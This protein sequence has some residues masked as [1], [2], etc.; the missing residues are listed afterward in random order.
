MATLLTAAP[1]I[2][3]QLEQLK[4]DCHDLKKRG[5]TPRMHVLLVGEHPPSVVYTRNK[6]RFC[7]SFGAECEI[8]RLPESISERDF[9]A[10][11]QEMTQDSKVHGCFVQLPLPQHLA[12]IDVGQLIPPHKDV[13]GFHGDN[14]MALLRGE[15]DKALV[16]CTP[17][18][19]L[20]L[21]DAYQIPLAGQHVLIIGRSLIVGK[22]LTLLMTE[23]NATV[24]LAH[25]KTRHLP[26]LAQSADMI[27]TAIG[28]AKFLTAEYVRADQS[29]VFIDVGINHDEHGKLCGDMDF[30]ALH[31]KVKAITPVPGGVGKMTIL[32]LAQNLLQA[33]RN[34]L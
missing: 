32:S 17:K 1:V 34:S 30:D 26:E 4:Q 7:E 14:L 15:S 27:V 29:Q 24:T 23:K 12:H 9:L 21:L 2:E 3:S 25:S 31:P 19:I 20:T 8:V 18:G 10:A 5:V 13:D 33:C 6:K 28:R 16:P 22:P 11:V